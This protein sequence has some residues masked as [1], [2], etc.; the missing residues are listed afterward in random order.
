MQVIETLKNA[1]IIK[2][3]EHIYSVNEVMK[4]GSYKNVC[5]FKVNDDVISINTY[6][7]VI[8]NAIGIS[9]IKIN[10]CD[11]SFQYNIIIGNVLL[12]SGE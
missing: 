9:Y 4:D 8:S 12:L 10:K 7:K 11:V 6:I 3:S 2:Y 1:G 5:D